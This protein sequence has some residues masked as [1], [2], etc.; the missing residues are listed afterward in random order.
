MTESGWDAVYRKTGFSG[1]DG[2]AKVHA[3]GVGVASVMLTTAVTEQESRYP[4]VNIIVSD[5]P[6]TNLVDAIRPLFQNLT[7]QVTSIAKLLEVDLNNK[8]GIVLAMEELLLSN[9]DEITFKRMQDLFSTARGILWV[10]RGVRLHN[11]EVNM[12]TGVA[13]CLRTEFVGLRLV[14]LDLDE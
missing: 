10:S 5:K 7:G 12:F 4:Q 1:L 2:S 6:H 13:R 11:P 3:Y 9:F 8:Y 14:T